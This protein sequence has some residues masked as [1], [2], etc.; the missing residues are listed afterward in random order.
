MY[1]HLLSQNCIIYLGEL[2]KTNTDLQKRMV[3]KLDDE[4]QVAVFSVQQEED[5]SYNKQTRNRGEGKSLSTGASLTTGC[6]K[7]IID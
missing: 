7:K 2:Q 4:V 3:Q 1:V 6:R 5:K